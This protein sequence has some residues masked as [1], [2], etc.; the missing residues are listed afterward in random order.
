[1][2]SETDTFA[3]VNANFDFDSVLNNCPYKKYMQVRELHT[4]SKSRD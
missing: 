2:T 3:F 4:V 1:M